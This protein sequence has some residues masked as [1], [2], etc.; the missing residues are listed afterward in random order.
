MNRLVRN[1]AV[2]I[3]LI[4]PSLGR[5]QETLT[6]ASVTGRVLDTSGALI[7]HATVKALALATN[8][9]YTVT[10]DDQGRFRIPF[11]V[12]GIYSFSTQPAGFALT[13][14]KVQLTVGAALDVT[15]RVAVGSANTSVDV[16]GQPPVLEE[17]RSQISETVLQ[18]E[19]NDLPYNGRNFLDLSLLA[20][21]VSPT[22]TG[23]VQTFA[24]TS[25]V[26]GQGYSINS[27]RNFSNSF[28]VD[29]LSA[30]DD[31]AGL[32]GNSYSMDVVREFQ[33]V[34][35]GGQAE[36]G[37]A[38]GG[39]FNIVTRSGT[40][41]LHGTAYGFLKNQR[42]N[43]QNALSG[44]K[45]PLTQGQ[46]GASLS[47]PVT[48][49]H[50]FLFGNYEGRRL[51]TNGVT[52]IAPAQASAINSRLDAIGFVGP[53]LSVGTGPTTLYPTTVHTD[54]AFLRGDHRFSDIDQINLRY[55]FYH[56]DSINARGAGGIA[57]VSYGTSVRDTNH[58]VAVSNVATLSPRT[59]NETRGQFTYDD[60]EAPPNTQN[61][62][63]VTISGVATFGRFS[64]SPT[65]RLNYLYEL[66][67][68]F[69]MQRRTHTVKAGAD[70]LFNN[71][72]ITFPMAFAGS[73]LFP[74]LSAFQSSGRS[75]SSFSQNFGTPFIQ[76]NNPNI[77][78]YVQDEWKIASTLTL[79]LGLRYDLQFLRTINTDINNV[80]PRI[81]FA[82]SPFA[83]KRIV[84]RG[85]FGLFYDRVPL[86][87]L[88]NA[89]LSADNTTDPARGRLLQ[90][91]Y[92]PSDTGAPV[93][94]NVSSTPNPG[95]RI[96][97]TLMNR[98]IQNASSQQASLGVEQQIT[99]TA[100][101]GISYQHVRGLHLLS[102]INRNIN[103]DGS[104][105]DPTRGNVRPYD[106]LFDSSY[107]GLAVSFLERPVSWGSARISYT[108]SKAMANVGEFFFSSPI[109][110]FDLR[111]DRSRSD[112]DQRHRLVFDATL[113]SP[114]AH[115]D[116]ITGHLTHGW[117]MGG[118]LQYYSRL[119]FNITTGGQT[120]QQTTQR[121][122]AAGYSLVGI[123]P[124]TEA[125]AGAV[126]NRN[127]GV[128]FDFFSLNARLSRTF[129][130]TER[131]HLEGMVEAFNVLNHRNDMIPNATW[132]TGDYPSRPNPS[133]GAATAVG[134]PRSIQLAARLSF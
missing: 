42:L 69:V 84:V 50:T 38:L 52:T 97:Y 12:I 51:N 65:A 111:M 106:S 73:Y 34:T 43:A 44:N 126:I 129:P 124:C 121:P 87:P 59:F 70:F 58:T 103:P 7:P 14:Q 46:Y 18:A 116:R 23:S 74:S 47:G 21:G 107:D 56:L 122:C 75:Y 112:D 82:W 109:N 25:P 114:T 55:S 96:S 81:G 119:P 5:A 105:P 83:N 48:R 133:F 13:A 120:T 66:V 27:Q 17:N 4:V 53:R 130:I 90:Y 91:T 41:D 10:T 104:R 115:T 101:L 16:A 80:S 77:G 24:E 100:T 79:N 68:N 6:T 9:A 29:G 40:N 71:D 26:I 62:P 95:S 108:W 132:G 99:Q 89:L 94:P 113:T 118:I 125:L 39:Y 92:I 49:D 78:M 61:S 76:Q 67:D 60:L 28:V 20:P 134:D 63:A 15:L 102:S 54:T 64:S 22:N 57:D 117:R 36:F 131:F 37:R 32:A 127:A 33:V 128:G 31:A 85:S 11:L 2:L 1:M 93:F 35:S 19:V 110:N 72:T 30:N 123:N 8:Q 98:S 86:R 45:L 3:S 88:A